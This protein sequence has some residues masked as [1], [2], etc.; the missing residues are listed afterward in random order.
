MELTQVL[1][2][3]VQ[4]WPDTTATV[5]ADRTRTWRESAARVERLAGGLRE[6]GVGPGDRVAILS[7]NSDIYHEFM[8][9]ACWAGTV[10]VPINTRW[11]PGEI[12]FSLEDSEARVLLV[13]ET[14]ALLIPELR[15]RA[16][17]LETV[18]YAGVAPVPGGMI[19]VEDVI[20]AG[21][22]I[23]DARRGGDALAAIYYTGGTTGR[24][25][26][27]MLTHHSLLAS[28]LSAVATG[29]WLR[30]GARYLH[31][32]PMF[33][34]ADICGW[35]SVN[36]VGGTHVF[37][38]RFDPA[39]VARAIE[40]H[41]ITEMVVVPTMIQ[42]LIDAPE[43]ADY[44]LSSLRRLL[45][46][47]SPI[48]PSLLDRVAARLPDVELTQSYAMTEMS[49]VMTLLAPDEH[50]DPRLRTSAGRAAPLV[51]LRIAD[52]QGHDVANGVIGQI[53]ARGDGLM[54][55]YWNRPEETAAALAGG[56]MHTGDTGYLDDAGYLFVVDRIKDMIITG[57]E[58]VYS[59]EVEKALATHPDVSACAVI[60]LPDQ[61]WGER[62]HAVVVPMA[63]AEPTPAELRDHVRQ[64]IATYKVPRT[65]EFLES[66]P[67]S[68][69]G[70]ILKREL[71]Q[72]HSV[73]RE[74]QAK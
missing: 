35:V 13:D 51:E 49:P 30:P 2:R 19:S 63:G 41:R 62:V 28:T 32:A 27:V 45:Y 43:A 59:T 55:G 74:R 73:D 14:F 29:D 10:F 17:C 31:A 39:A 7:L 23:P 47:G 37:L 44:D 18:L 38:P 60:G 71:R 6:L 50:R 33:H 3:A 9:A 61:R 5:F 52:D 69:A 16:T 8:L 68:G 20:S 15:S 57:G 24:P 46:G 70:K 65:F 66:I 11:S 67:F 4:Q 22:P 53:L 34:S 72:R 48:T 40:Q 64:L 54:L 1:H 26:G 56:W 21:R 12:G 42:M 25:K 36:A 58:N